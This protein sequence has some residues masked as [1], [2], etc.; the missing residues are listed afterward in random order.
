ME[1][2]GG[3]SKIIEESKEKLNEMTVENDKLK[4]GN[5]KGMEGKMNKT[6]K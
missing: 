5:V 6:G 4:E 3:E 1:K 2:K